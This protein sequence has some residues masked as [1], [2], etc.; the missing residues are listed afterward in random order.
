MSDP[1]MQF[2]TEVVT[3][4]VKLGEYL[5]NPDAVLDRYGISREDREVIKRGGPDVLARRLTLAARAGVLPGPAGLAGT[6]PPEEP[7]A[8]IPTWGAPANGQPLSGGADRVSTPVSGGAP[9][10]EPEPAAH[11]PEAGPDAGPAAV[12]RV[13]LP[14]G[15]AAS[16][17]I[18][19]VPSACGCPHCR[20]AAG[21]GEPG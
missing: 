18:Y 10:A 14:G 13:P 12:R 16:V 21:E 5:R 8:P 7:S 17:A 20:A 11:V 9:L 6:S 4:A 1:L 15:H 2:V 3:D 19:I